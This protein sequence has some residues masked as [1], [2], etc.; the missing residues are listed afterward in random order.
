MRL[1]GRWASEY[2]LFA[3]AAATVGVP[4]VFL[5][6]DEAICEEVRAFNP[7]CRTF[8]VKRGQGA[9]TVNLHPSA[10]L[11]G[12]RAG[13]E[14]ALRGEREAAKLALPESFVLEIDYKEQQAAYQ[15]AFYPGASLPS[16]TTARLEA[17]DYF[18]VL[19][20]VMFLH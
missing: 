4:V 5:S 13:C 7:A 8:A 3:Q 6:G 14:A 20:A 18:D 9:T 11:D 15:K 16:P 1:N 17:E 2:L 10:A 12:I 19:R